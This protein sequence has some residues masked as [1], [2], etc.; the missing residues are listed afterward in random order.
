MENFATRFADLLENASLKVRS[1]TVD[2]ADRVIK[3]ASL[4][5]VAATL[6]AVALIFLAV[7]IFRAV[8]EPLTVPWTYAL[9]GGLFVVGGAIVWAVRKRAPKD[10][11]G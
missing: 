11:N 10:G 7:A 8:A 2:R 3:I 1:Q 5:L 6:V 4:G 9:F